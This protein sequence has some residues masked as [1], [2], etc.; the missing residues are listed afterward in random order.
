MTIQRNS[1]HILDLNRILKRKPHKFSG[2]EGPS[3]VSTIHNLPNG[4][5]NLKMGMNN[6]PSQSTTKDGL[7]NS[8]GNMDLGKSGGSGTD[9]GET[10]EKI[11]GSQV[12]GAISTV[13]GG[14]AGMYA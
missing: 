8:A 1:N 14:L 4:A 9:G 10:K 12:A 11:T 7:P 3:N 5:G 13:A 2:L 6:I